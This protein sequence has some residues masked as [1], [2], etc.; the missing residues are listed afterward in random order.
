MARGSGGGIPRKT[1]DRHAPSWQPSHNRRLFRAVRRGGCAARGARCHYNAP[2]RGVRALA[3]ATSKDGGLLRNLRLYPW[4]RAATE[5]LP[6][7]PVLVL[8][9]TERLPLQ[10]VLWLQGGYYTAIVFFEVPSGYL[11]DRLGRRP[12]LLASALGALGAPVCFLCGE[13]F[14]LLLCGEVLLAAAMALRS[15]TQTVLLYE[16]LQALG[17]EREFA[18]HEAQAQRWALVAAAIAAV[19]GGASGAVDVRLP[20]VLSLFTAFAMFV[21]GWL[22]REP[23]VQRGTAVGRGTV[24]VLRHCCCDLKQPA[25]RWLLAYAVVS[26]VLMKVPIEFY[27]PYLRLLEQNGAIGDARAPLVSGALLA[28]NLTL[29]AWV[30]VRS[31][32]W[33]RRL[34][35]VRLL[36]VALAFQVLLIAGLAALLHPATLALI[37]LRNVPMALTH[38]ALH[39]SLIPRLASE[40]RT[41]HLSL[42][43]MA[44]RLT[45]AA[46]LALVSALAAAPAASIDWPTLS[47][48]LRV[49]S[50]LGVGGVLLLWWKLARSQLRL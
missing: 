43:S 25:L 42:Q 10:Q 33:L 40:R 11:A 17:A 20:L 2:G 9:L 50:V 38:V 19:V 35:T 49:F 46:L 18:S 8:F 4:H 48:I 47:Y 31:L 27:Q 15:G 21:S 26:F 23:A 6:W 14:G 12:V 22:L 1:S 44:A 24:G 5:A 45:F 36:F 39:T 13:T 29:G 34:G 7:L 32:G 30:S 37:L 28:S 3:C 16:T 41:T